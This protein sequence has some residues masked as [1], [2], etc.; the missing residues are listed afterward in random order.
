MRFT[1]NNGAILKDRRAITLLGTKPEDI[2]DQLSGSRAE[3]HVSFLSF[4]LRSI[5]PNV[6]Q[7]LLLSSNFPSFYFMFHFEFQG[8][9]IRYLLNPLWNHFQV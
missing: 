5:E 3:Y 6:P 4:I 1:F 9:S 2:L 7:R 8:S